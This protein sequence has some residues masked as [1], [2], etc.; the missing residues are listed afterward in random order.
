MP[1]HA[2]HATHA[3]ITR[4]EHAQYYKDGRHLQGKR[5]SIEWE[6]LFDRLCHPTI[7]ANKLDLPLW[8]PTI[9]PG[10]NRREMNDRGEKNNPIEVCA[11]VLD[12]D[13]GATL[14]AGMN[15]IE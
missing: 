13:H 6:R 14:A 3:T 2:T 10:D 7:A 1:R 15:A 9:W 12:V 5:Y 8:A 4:F 11:L